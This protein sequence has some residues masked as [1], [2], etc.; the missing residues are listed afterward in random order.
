MSLWCKLVVICDS[1][2]KKEHNPPYVPSPVPSEPE[3]LQGHP[4][5]GIYSTRLQQDAAVG[6]LNALWGQVCQVGR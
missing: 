5:H 2:H 4:S 3:N 1:T 6:L